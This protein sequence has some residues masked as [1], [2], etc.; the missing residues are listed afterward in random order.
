MN[1]FDE[2]CE[3]LGLRDV[4]GQAEMDRQR[5]FADPAATA[6]CGGGRSSEWF[7]A[8]LRGRGR[9]TPGRITR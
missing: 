3:K 9:A 5:F 7:A 1:H 6:C 2:L 4:L 8:L